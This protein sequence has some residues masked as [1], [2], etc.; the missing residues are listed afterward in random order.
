MLTISRFASLLAVLSLVTSPAIAQTADETSR[1]NIERLL[2]L[3]HASAMGAQL[4]AVVSG[5]MIAQLKAK[6]PNLPE[7]AVE[8]VREV[9]GTEFGG[10]FNGASGVRSEMIELYGKHFTPE[11]VKGL[12]DFYGSPLGRKLATVLPALQ[13]DTAIIGQKWTQANMQRIASIVQQRFRQE[14]LVK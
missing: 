4:S 5:Q 2:E 8:I 7:R 14:G 11:E 1:G 3:T 9:L 12:L 6:Q 10:M 13:R